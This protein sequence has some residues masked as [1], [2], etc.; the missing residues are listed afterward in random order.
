LAVGVAFVQGLGL[1]SAACDAL[2]GFG[3]AEALESHSLPLTAEEIREVDAR[4]SRA[5]A[6]WR[7]DEFTHRR[8]RAHAVRLWGLWG[9]CKRG[10]ML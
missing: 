9:L 10:S 8:C 5:V 3:L 6:L 4:A 2:A 1:E 7:D